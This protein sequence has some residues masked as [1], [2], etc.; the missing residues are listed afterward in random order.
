[1]RGFQG[2][3]GFTGGSGTT[4]PTGP[5]GGIGWPFLPLSPTGPT[6]WQGKTGPTGIAGI[7]ATGP[8]GTI[9]TGSTGIT[10]PT[11]DASL[12]FY[13]SRSISHPIELYISNI[14]T[15][16]TLTSVITT[17]YA[18]VG[19]NMVMISCNYTWNSVTIPI[20]GNLR[21]SLPVALRTGPLNPYVIVGTY[22]GINLFST[23]VEAGTMFG[24]VESTWI[25]FV[26]YNRSTFSAR[27]VS[28]TNVLPSGSLNFSVIYP[29]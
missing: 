14:T 7:S 17:Q 3:T 29:I 5:P 27:P 4:G 12:P 10:G 15:D 18:I 22:T 21:A 25:N 2:P 28:D 23:S 9:L 8:T 26:F 19:T 24:L 11:G 13:S 20:S 6:G 1:M 16:Y